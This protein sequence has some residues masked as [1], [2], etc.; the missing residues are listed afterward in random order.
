MS[1][2]LK[3]YIPFMS[4]IIE[5]AEEKI[6][7]HRLIR[8]KFKSNEEF[9]IFTIIWLRVFKSL[10]QTIKREKSTKFNINTEDLYDKYIKSFYKNQRNQYLGMT[11]NAITRESDMP[12]STVKR[13]V[14]NL[15]VKNLLSR[16][17]KRLIIPTPQV[18]DVM[19][20]YRKY[21]F[22]S[23]KKNFKIYKELNID[24]RYD[25]TDIS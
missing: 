11:I 10:V 14:E 3:K 22:D 9:I 25:E 12:R 7:E 17:S 24:S 16:N 1:D 18:R 19:K 15:I 13:I 8:K 4:W 6:I 5:I 20:E 23:N 2:K 21:I